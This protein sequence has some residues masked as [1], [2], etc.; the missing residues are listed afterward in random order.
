MSYEH[1]ILNNV[2][3]C[4]TFMSS[5]QIRIDKIPDVLII[6]YRDLNRYVFEYVD[7]SISQYADW[8]ATTNKAED[9]ELELRGKV[10]LFGSAYGVDM[11]AYLDMWFE[12]LDKH[13]L[14][15]LDD[16]VRRIHDGTSRSLVFKA[17]VFTDGTIAIENMGEATHG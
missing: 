10:S 9:V 5:F 11:S 3:L 1:F 13:V 15:I 16:C 14:C 17:H 7:D 4:E 6:D 8:C 12:A 2:A